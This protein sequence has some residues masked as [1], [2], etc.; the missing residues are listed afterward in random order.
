M[1]RDYF[2][3]KTKIGFA[4]VTDDLDVEPTSITSNLQLNPS[5]FHKKGDPFISKYSGLQVRYRTVW[6]INSEWTVHEEETVSHHIEYFK[7]LL[8]PKTDIL[9]KYK[10]DNRFEL[11]FWITIY[12]DNAGIGLDLNEDEMNFLNNFSNRVHFSMIAN[13]DIDCNKKESSNEN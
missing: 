13:D 1:E 5:R 4:I 12:T 6:E 9:K 11:S 2:I 8:L 7:E 3:L 10:E